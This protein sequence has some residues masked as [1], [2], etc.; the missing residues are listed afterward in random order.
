MH[1]GNNAEREMAW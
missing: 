1:A